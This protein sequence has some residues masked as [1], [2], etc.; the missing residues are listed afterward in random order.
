MIAF[1]E[2]FLI[3][4]S[5]QEHPDAEAVRSTG[6]PMYNQLHIIFVEPEISGKHNRSTKEGE[7]TPGSVPQ[8]HLNISAEELSPSG[9]DKYT[10]L[11]NRKRSRGGIENGIAKGILEIASATKFR[12]EAIKKRNEEFSITD[13][14]K[15]LDELID[16]ISD[17]VY[18]VALDLFTNRNARETFL[19]LK[20]EK[21]SIWLQGKCMGNN[22]P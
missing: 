21:R 8:Q 1:H 5:N 9:S 4:Y 20:V 12:A 7:E 16:F 22:I 19:S 15:A 10:D 3:Q 14:I 18:F 11:A 6:C 17:Q 2:N 13:C